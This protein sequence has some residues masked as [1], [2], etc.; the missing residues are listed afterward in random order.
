MSRLLISVHEV[1]LSYRTLV[2]HQPDLI[3]E[4]RPRLSEVALCFSWTY[5]W[6]TWPSFWE[7][8]GLISFRS[9]V[10]CSY[11]FVKP[12]FSVF[13]MSAMLVTT[14]VAVRW[15]FKSDCSESCESVDFCTGG[16]VG[17]WPLGIGGSRGWE[18][19]E[20]IKGLSW[21]LDPLPFYTQ[22]TGLLV[23]WW[24][25]CH[26]CICIEKSAVF[27]MIYV[28]IILNNISCFDYYYN[29]LIYVSK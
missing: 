19:E 13:F 22:F 14:W 10:L 20:R 7:C 12:L 15:N 28:F 23:T 24:Q 3:F 25:S 17:A 8:I 29:F 16:G 26:H 2:F 21:K 9:R 6:P 5:M 11:H 1:A 18:C 27:I 4:D